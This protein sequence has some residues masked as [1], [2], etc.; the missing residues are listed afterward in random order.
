LGQYFDHQGIFLLQVLA[1]PILLNLLLIVVLNMREA[2]N[3]LVQLKRK[4]LK[5]KDRA[6]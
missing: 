1:L 5:R 2:T 6:E 3:L 4:Q